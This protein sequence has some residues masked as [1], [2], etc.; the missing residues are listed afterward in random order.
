MKTIKET[1][2]V[3]LLLLLFH[4]EMVEIY[5]DVWIQCN[6]YNVEKVEKKKALQS[7]FD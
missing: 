7:T 6:W 4:V 3:L 5:I 1:H 2:T